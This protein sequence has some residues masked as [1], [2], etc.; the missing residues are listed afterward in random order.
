MKIV[1]SIL[2]I[3]IYLPLRT[4]SKVLSAAHKISVY[5]FPRGKDARKFFMSEKEG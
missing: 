5:F 4:T 3:M 2:S 1:I